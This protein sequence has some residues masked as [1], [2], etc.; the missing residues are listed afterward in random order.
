M[1][2]AGNCISGDAYVTA[3]QEQADAIRNQALVEVG[4]STVL[5]LWQR[6]SS[7]SIASMQEAIAKRNL[8]LAREA[9]EHAKEFWECRKELVEWAFGEAKYEIQ[10]DELANQFKEFGRKTMDD[11]EQ[12]WT[13][14]VERH[15]L[16]LTPCHT[17]RWDRFSAALD[18]DLVSFGDRQA[19]A[20]AQTLNDRRYARRVA[21]LALGKGIM[22]NVA[23]FSELHGVAGL[24]AGALLGGAINSGMEAL[25]YYMR[26]ERTTQWDSSSETY[27]MPYRIPENIGTTAAPVGY[28]VSVGTVKDEPFDVCHEPTAEER[29]RNPEA[30]NEY[31]RCVGRYK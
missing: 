7:K 10:S 29:R 20:R 18:A 13:D 4:V 12:S 16:P 1:S 30:Y 27:R 21:A 22:T 11:A 17:S 25:G 28:E 8:R 5:A 24:N 15:C 31:L 14:D 2:D 9:Y 19:E 26:R 6:N 3:A 23:S